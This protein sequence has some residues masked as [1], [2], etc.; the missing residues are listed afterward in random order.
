MGI[1][2][3]SC[4]KISAE[5]DAVYCKYCGFRY[6]RTELEALKNVYI[7][8]NESQKKSEKNTKIQIRIS[9]VS[10]IFSAIAF[11]IAV[12]AILIST[13]ALPVEQRV[14]GIIIIFSIMAFAYWFIKEYG[15]SIDVDEIE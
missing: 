8:I 5:E 4:G 13:F 2:C 9:F 6:A 11:V 7:L 14:V 12:G 10:V 15:I 1:Q 3:E